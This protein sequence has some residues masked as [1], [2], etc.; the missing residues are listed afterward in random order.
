M[1]LLLI[2]IIIFVPL[3]NISALENKIIAKIENEII[4]LIDVENEKNYLK[5]LNPNI[6]DIDEE[7]LN[8]ISKNSLIREKIKE[9]EILKYTDKIKLNEKFLNGLVEQRYSRLKLNN[10]KQFL[11]YIKQYNVNIKTIEKKLSI[12][13]IWN[14][15]IYQKFSKNIKIDKNE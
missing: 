14:Q 8:L 4:T 11:N 5:A 7:R 10:K 1:R 15:L 6:R 2:S 12:E 3:K 13:A 9:N